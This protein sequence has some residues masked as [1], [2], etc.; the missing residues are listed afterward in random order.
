MI[1]DE[2]LMTLKIDSVENRIENRIEWSEA[3]VERILQKSNFIM[4]EYVSLILS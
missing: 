2:Q 3:F 1:T 4:N